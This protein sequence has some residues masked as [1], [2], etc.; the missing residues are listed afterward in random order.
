MAAVFRQGFWVMSLGVIVLFAFFA[1]LG[2]FSPGDVAPVTGV[3]VILVVLWLGHFWA[4]RRHRDEISRDPSLRHDR[5]RRG[6]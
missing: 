5:E 6:F 4:L 3:V 2:A 1:A